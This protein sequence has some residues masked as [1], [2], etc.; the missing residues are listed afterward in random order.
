M[1]MLVF[2]AFPIQKWFLLMDNKLYL[3][4][5]FLQELLQLGAA[6]ISS[7]EHVLSVDDLADQIA[8]VLNYFG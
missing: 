3:I 1:L 4:W 8:E 5:Y 7:D 6:A 2:H